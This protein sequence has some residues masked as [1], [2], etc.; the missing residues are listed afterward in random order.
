[1]SD[2]AAQFSDRQVIK[3]RGKYWILRCEVHS[4]LRLTKE[5]GKEHLESE[6][7]LEVK[8]FDMTLGYIGINIS[9]YTE[10]TELQSSDRPLPTARRSQ[11]AGGRRNNT[12]ERRT[13]GSP[14]A[15]PITKGHRAEQ[16]AATAT[17]EQAARPVSLREEQAAV[18][19]LQTANPNSR[20]RLEWYICY[21][22]C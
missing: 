15:L 16:G 17:M 13:D 6:H 8:S 22:I 18:N 2:Y 3:H 12:R 10:S 1:M 11:E 21:L 4:G 19:G 5:N 7:Q 14:S 20:A 9:D